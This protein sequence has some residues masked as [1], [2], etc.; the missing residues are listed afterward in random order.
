MELKDKLTHLRKE[1]GLSQLELAEVMNV[2]RQAVSRWET[3]LSIPS[4]DKLKGLSELYGVS[5]DTLLRSEGE[6]PRPITSEPDADAKVCESKKEDPKKY[7]RLSK[8]IIVLLCIVLLTAAIA[9]IFAGR[10]RTSNHIVMSNIE[11]E[12]VFS[13]SAENF[14]IDW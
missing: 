13:E 8:Y 14:S 9:I 7:I 10:H 11:P 2:S 3:G 12:E 6:Y 4:T 5:L 1:K